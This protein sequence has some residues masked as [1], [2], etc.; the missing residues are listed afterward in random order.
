M[1]RTKA[2]SVMSWEIKIMGNKDDF[3][4]GEKIKSREIK[5]FIGNSHEGEAIDMLT[6][7][8]ERA[9]LFCSQ[10]LYLAEEGYFDDLTSGAARVPK[11]L[12]V[13]RVINCGS[14]RFMIVANDYDMLTAEYYFLL[15][16][17]ELSKI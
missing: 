17:N 11:T 8:Y 15:K 10:K 7:H 12:I 14:N 2:T 5:D 3:S 6:P 1:E 4:I 13:H 9:Y 16:G